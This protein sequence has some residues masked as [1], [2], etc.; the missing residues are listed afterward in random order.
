MKLKGK[1]LGA[2]ILAI[3]LF[4]MPAV[5]ITLD[6]CFETII[7]VDGC[8]SQI[9]TKEMLQQMIIA[10]MKDSSDEEIAEA[11]KKVEPIK[12]IGAAEF[13]K[14]EVE[15]A[16]LIEVAISKITKTENMMFAKEDGDG[17]KHSRMWMLTE[18]D[19][20]TIFA[21]ETVDGAYYSVGKIELEGENL[22]ES[23]VMKMFGK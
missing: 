16:E 5:A 15:D 21:V 3:S 9:L 13:K 14:I 4:N 22:D 19:G 1:F 12:M 23:S 20:I 18:E 10:G 7:S 17:K 2:V 8:E 6:E 11:M